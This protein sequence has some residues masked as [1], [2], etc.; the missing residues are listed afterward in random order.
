[1]ALSNED[2]KYA[3]AVVGLTRL[4]DRT[5]QTLVL[6]IIPQIVQ[7]LLAASNKATDKTVQSE[8]AKVLGALKL[9]CLPSINSALDSR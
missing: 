7:N 1:M 3:G 8:V 6:P 4:G 9:A 5:V 2:K